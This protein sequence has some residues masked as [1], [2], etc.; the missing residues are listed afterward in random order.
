MSLFCLKS[1]YLNMVLLVL[2]VD[3]QANVEVSTWPG[4]IYHSPFS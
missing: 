4:L 2:P 3:G 1:I